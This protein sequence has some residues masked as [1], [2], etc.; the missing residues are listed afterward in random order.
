MSDI[1]IGIIG[2]SG[3]YDIDG[4]EMIEELDIN[5]PFGKPSD[6]IRVG[7]IGDRKVAF[8]PRHGR[9]HVHNPT[10]IPVRANIW[11]LKSLGV[12]W[13]TTISAVGSLREEIRPRDFVI[14]DD[15]ID[16]TRNRVDTFFDDLA[17]HAG[18]SQ[19][20]HPM[21]REVLLQACRDTGVTVHD[22]GTYVCM[23]GPLFSTPAESRMHRSWGASL[24]GMT[25][26]P[27]AKLAREAEM[28]Y[29]SI[30]LAT[31]YD[32]WKDDQN[33]DVSEVLDN[34]RANVANVQEVIRRLVPLVPL[35]REEECDASS[36]L[37]HAIMTHPDHITDDTWSRVGLFLRKY[38]PR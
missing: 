16:R 30:C 9:G 28:C 23:E 4:V 8:L 33:V 38:I 25:A 21:L 17:V 3:V 26:L 13:L 29:A 1:R 37:R 20:F 36:A 12:F 31:D 27:E 6:T 22:G 11:A 34:V 10:R 19:A 2:G 15:V 14:P 7:R 24:I 5:T 35:G 32:V 18:F